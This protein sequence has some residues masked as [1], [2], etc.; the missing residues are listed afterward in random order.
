[1]GLAFVSEVSR[2][3]KCYAESSALESISPMAVMVLPA[4][5]LQKPFPNAKTKVLVDCHERRLTL[6]KEGNIPALVKEGQAFQSKLSSAPH[7]KQRECRAKTFSKLMK[8][9]KVKAAMKHQSSL[10]VRWSSHP[11]EKPGLCW[12]SLKPNIHRNEK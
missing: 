10:S 12:R 11:M 8:Q 7:K 9:G 1:M 5:V 4:L 6:W 3:F 2:L